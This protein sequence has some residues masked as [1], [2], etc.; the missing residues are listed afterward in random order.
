MCGRQELF[1]PSQTLRTF[2]S[3]P[4]Y[5][6]RRREQIVVC[7]P[8]INSLDT[9][10]EHTHPEPNIR[11]LQ[12]R[13]HPSALCGLLRACCGWAARWSVQN[14]P[15][16]HAE[17]RPA[18]SSTDRAVCSSAQQPTAAPPPPVA[19]PTPGP[20]STDTLKAGRTTSRRRLRT[21]PRCACMR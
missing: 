3:S 11:T 20:P 12:C 19:P 15:P 21:R 8:R 17:M 2:Q 6:L 4:V 16:L 1:G 5:S 9:D 13:L 7:A 14:T 10:R 18:A